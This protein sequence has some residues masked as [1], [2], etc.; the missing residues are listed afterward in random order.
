MVVNYRHNIMKI[1]TI[2]NFVN[3][4][5]GLNNNTRDV[6]F[7]RAI[8][9]DKDLIK[10]LCEIE[11]KLTEEAV[12]KRIAYKRISSLKRLTEIADSDFYSALYDNLNNGRV[13]EFRN[14]KGGNDLYN[15]IFNALKKIEPIYIKSRP[16]VTASMIRNLMVKLLF[17]LDYEMGE[18]LTNWNERKCIKVI[19]D[20]IEKE[21]D[22][23]YYVVL[24]FIGCDVL[25]VENRCDVSTSKELLA[26]SEKVI[27]GEY[28]K[29]K[30]IP[31]VREKEV[32]DQKEIKAIHED[33]KKSTSVKIPPRPTKSRNRINDRISSNGVIAAP[34]RSSQPALKERAEKSYEELAQLA[35]SVVLIAVHDRDGEIMGTGSGIMIGEK[36]YILTNHHV[37]VGGHFYSVRIED[38]EEVYATDEVIKY[39]SVID[40]AVIRIKRRL[41]PIPLY[42]GSKLVRGQKVV[43]I[44]SPLGLFN[45][46]S[47]GI[48]SGF[49]NINDVDMIQ[50]TAPISHGSSGG[51]VLNMNGEII[52]ISTAG[53]DSGQ[54]INLA[55][56]YENINNFV[57]GFI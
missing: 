30:L 12:A 46:V 7:V 31:Y 14:I 10:N 45:S 28:G 13:A 47:D 11:K 9:E 6:Y 48:V 26:F 18:C 2:Q 44:G 23:I 51:A 19:A 27:L 53:I 41:K 3:I 49:R 22:Y 4:R 20:N 16:G 42:K 24:T 15:T 1:N 35:S 40:L 8:G 55:I 50:F 37:V 54:N 21:Q 39:N 52:G 57:R 5:G 29:T 25:L 36:G 34:P 33:E 38:D 32:A 17:W 56:G 43:A